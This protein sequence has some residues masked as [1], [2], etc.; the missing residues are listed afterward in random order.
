M[1]TQQQHV[2][3]RVGAAFLFFFFFLRKD[4][5]W[6]KYRSSIRHC[7]SRI[8]GALALYIIVVLYIT[9]KIEYIFE[10]E[11]GSTTAKVLLRLSCSHVAGSLYMRKYTT[12]ANHNIH[13]F[14]SHRGTWSLTHG[15]SM[16]L[17]AS[18]QSKN[19]PW[20]YVYE[21]LAASSQRRTRKAAPISYRSRLKTRARQK[22]W[23]AP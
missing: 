4:V 12:L 13:E 5:V 7:T 18:V 11:V 23:T 1:S 22:L 3:G 16:R 9:C 17:Y 20:S 10:V 14:I 21:S 15:T 8:P 6:E 19:A 2:L